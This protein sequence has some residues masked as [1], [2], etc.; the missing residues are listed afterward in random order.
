MLNMPVLELKLI[1][2]QVLQQNYFC[3]RYRLLTLLLIPKIWETDWIT[4]VYARNYVRNI[5]CEEVKR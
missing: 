1:T 5:L 4:P 3:F 2:S